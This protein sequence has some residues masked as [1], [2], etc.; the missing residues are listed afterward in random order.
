M[1]CQVKWG[2]CGS[3]YSQKYKLLKPQRET[4]RTYRASRDLSPY[5][6]VYDHLQF[7]VKPFSLVVP[8]PFKSD[9]SLRFH[10]KKKEL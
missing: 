7:L 4:Y 10:E 1:G 6:Q 9:S 2:G 8:V 3:T 5:L